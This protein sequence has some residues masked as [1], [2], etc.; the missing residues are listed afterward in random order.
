MY[1]I[2]QCQTCS[3]GDYSL[4]TGVGGQAQNRPGAVRAQGSG[5][6]DSEK[7]RSRSAQSETTYE[8]TVR[9]ED[10]DL[11]TISAKAVQ[12]SQATDYSSLYR[13]RD[14]VSSSTYRSRRRESSIE[15]SVEVEGDLSPEELADI[16]KLTGALSR[17]TKQVNRGDTSG[18]L[19]TAL[20]AETAD[21][22]IASF[23]FAYQHSKQ[24]EQTRSRQ[25]SYL[26]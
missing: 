10:G 23:D 9:T 19:L 8:L 14:A 20:R 4:P 15:V 24:V 2:S 12:S 22:S 21:D 26:G 17:A 25:I 13:D 16:R 6:I 7:A 5:S 18:A 3:P 1:A 11:V